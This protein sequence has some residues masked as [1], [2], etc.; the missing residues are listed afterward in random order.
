MGMR[1]AKQEWA[2]MWPLPLTAMFGIA[3]VSLFAYS[4]GIFMEPMT[5]AFGWSRVE[6]SSAFTVMMVTGLVGAPIAGRCV[7]A[8]GARK[9]A[10]F[11]I[12]PFALC[13]AALG[14]VN[15]PIWQWWAL[16]FA[17]ALFTCCVSTPVW[18]TPVVGRFQASRG[19]AL[20]VA[21]A[22]IGVSQTIWPPLATVY[23]GAFGWRLAFAALAL[24]WAVPM[25]ILAL[26]F[27]RDR[28]ESDAPG[29][30]AA[31]SA[32]PART[33]EKGAYRKAFATRTFI[34]L[35]V[36]GSLFAC[37]S[38]GTS[39]HL[40]PLLRQKGLGLGVAAGVISV[41]GI[42]AIIGRLSI[43]LMLDRMSTRVIS[44]CV[45]ALPL[46][47]ALLLWR[48]DNNLAVALTAAAI[49]GLAN[50]A[51]TDVI[52]YIIS[53]RFPHS[54]FASIYATGASFIAVSAS[55][56]PLLAGGLF[57]R[58]GSYDYFLLAIVPMALA[59]VV[60]VA[61]IPPLSAAERGTR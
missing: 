56:G 42:S 16:A 58:F 21:L 24:T 40:V 13:L 36:A 48:A 59:S 20:A 14:L 5:A 44:I 31:A 51:E 57:D 6:F 54:M 49:F 7:D 28:T 27:F 26:L 50:G 33:V 52:A 4:S 12:V 53:R 8:F 19:L 22:G 37:I 35:M 43:G 38:Y 10:L 60:L 17:F 30:G 55:V 32:D 45:F 25:L 41:T 46:L 23:I 9:V 34:C 11:G 39:I 61:L 47:V 15:G 3:G 18:I 1:S 2:A 29:A